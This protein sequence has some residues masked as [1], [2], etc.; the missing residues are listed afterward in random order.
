MSTSPDSSSALRLKCSSFGDTVQSQLAAASEGSKT[1]IAPKASLDSYNAFYL[2]VLSYTSGV[3]S[4]A[5][6]A[7]ELS[8]GV[9]DLKDGTATLK[10]G[11]AKLY[12]GVLTLQDGMPALISGITELRDGAM[13]LSDGLEQFNEEGIQKLVNLIDEDLDGVM[14][15]LKAT[16]DVSK[17]YTN[18]SGIGDGMDGQVKFIYR[19]DEIKAN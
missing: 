2:G 11:A 14:V 6:G 19:T 15:R 3:D 7:G 10:A 16:V 17:H 18:F 4:A 12:S 5:S 1:I 13:A 8:D 9:S